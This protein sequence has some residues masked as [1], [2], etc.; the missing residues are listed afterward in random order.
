MP[1]STI[2]IRNEDYELWQSLPDKSGFVREALQSYRPKVEGKPPKGKFC[3][4]GA[5]YGF[6]IFNCV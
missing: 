1:R 2:W 3:K 4:H 5:V 6:C